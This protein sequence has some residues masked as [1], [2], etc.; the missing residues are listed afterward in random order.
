VDIATER[1]IT[2]H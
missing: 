1:A 2:I